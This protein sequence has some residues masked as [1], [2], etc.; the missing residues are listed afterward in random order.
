MLE[1][2]NRRRLQ[3]WFA[4]IT[5]LAAIMFSAWIM[6]DRL[7]RWL[8]LHLEDETFYLGHG[9]AFPE[10]KLQSASWGPLYSL[11]YWSVSQVFKVPM[12]KLYLLSHRILI[13]L[14]PGLLFVAMRSFRVG[15][16][17]ALVFS[18]LF[19]ISILNVSTEPKVG[20]FA[21]VVLLTT[22]ALSN[23]FPVAG[24][25]RWCCLMLGFLTASYSRPEF[26]LAFCLA[27]TVLIA[28]EVRARWGAVLEWKKSLWPILALVTAFA[29]LILCGLPVGSRSFLAFSQH[30]SLNWVSA[31][32]EAKLDG[33]TDYELI[34]GKVFGP[35]RSVTG[36][37]VANPSAFFSHI[38]RNIISLVSEIT[39]LTFSHRPLF[40]ASAHRWPLLESAL[41]IGVL[42]LWGTLRP[43]RGLQSIIQRM[44]SNA[45]VISPVLLPMIATLAGVLIVRPDAHYLVTL[46]AL[47]L[48]A[49]TGISAE[50][51]QLTQPCRSQILRPII[52]SACL[53]AISPPY[54]SKI[55]SLPGYAEIRYLKSLH[56]KT[57][58]VVL[59][60]S[61][62]GHRLLGKN[63]KTVSSW[64]KP[65]DEGFITFI[66]RQ[67]VN[68]IVVNKRMDEDSRYRDDEEWHRFKADP[69]SANFNEADLSG[70]DSGI[71]I[72]VRKIVVPSP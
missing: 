70:D 40:S 64:N 26:F 22:I 8:D 52:L 38:T 28:K 16:T 43:E 35:V 11:W 19:A 37:L 23:V 50:T 57:E 20:H 55:L 27:G 44:K 12:L 66:E 13:M 1:P 72:Y 65:Q 51:S 46:S 41:I 7:D 54:M 69:A 56:V 36:A 24:T 58:A 32:P 3:G 45:I 33:W 6:S 71:K 21:S 53:V 4:D 31:H 2:L 63:W 17:A 5:I 67:K 18:W 10:E 49:L 59:S 60:T 25:G 39:R 68:F 14:V 61:G 47:M 15:R 29:V 9:A 62:A 48:L 30:F 42:A 34:T